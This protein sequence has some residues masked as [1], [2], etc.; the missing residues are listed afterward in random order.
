MNREAFLVSRLSTNALRAL[1]YDRTVEALR[2]AAQ[3][4][5]VPRIRDLAT[6]GDRSYGS[7]FNGADCDPEFGISLVSQSALFSAEPVTRHIREASIPHL[8]HHLIRRWQVLVAG[9]G[10]L[11]ETELFGRAI[12][13]DARLAGRAIGPHAVAINFH[14]PE[15]DEA[16]FAYA[17]LASPTGLRAIRSTACGTKI[18]A[19]RLDM[20]LDL[21]IPPADASTKRRVAALVRQC[22]AQRELFLEE[23]RVARRVIEEMPEMLEAH[24]TCVER[25]PRAVKWSGP[26]STLCAWNYASAGEAHALLSKK[27]SGRF[28]DLV[29]RE[30]LFRG[31]RLRRIPCDRPYGIDFLNQRDVFSIRP[32]PRRIVEPVVPEDWIY[33]PE[34]SLLAGGHGTLGEGE[35]FGRVA[36]VSADL[37][38]AGVSE[39]L[40]RIQPVDRVATATLYAFLST[41]VGRRLLRSTGVGTKLL[42]LRPDLVFALPVPELT[43]TL[44]SKVVRHL[45]AACAAR[46]A[47][48]GAEEQAISV[49]EEEVLPA[50]L[51]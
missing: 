39:D 24:A 44:A 17:Y 23:L 46:V 27:W 33:V 10:T 5:Q 3:V 15:N 50:W 35:I 42:S 1:N 19:L 29:P 28:R 11:G 41:L 12:I 18:L 30:G 22:V 45:E 26:T 34:F 2:R 7:R 48:V 14:K 9:A 36:I 16:L 4:E 47:A 8:E 21:P 43:S 20:L 31:G 37:A 32:A 6:L 13:A 51:A 25:K 38:K 49:I 40:L